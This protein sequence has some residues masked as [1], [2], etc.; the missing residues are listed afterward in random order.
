M[1]P[2]KNRIVSV[3][4]VGAFYIVDYADGT[5][6]ITGKE[7]AEETARRIKASKRRKR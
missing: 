1:N 7:A 2:K 4:E 5:R 6:I 3:E